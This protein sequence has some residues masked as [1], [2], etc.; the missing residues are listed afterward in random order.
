MTKRSSN[1][2][3]GTLVAAGAGYVAGI[4]TAPKSGK[5]TRGDIQSAALKTKKDAET[6]LKNLH[7]ELN[8]LLKRGKDQAG[9]LKDKAQ[10]GLDEAISSAQ[11]AKDKASQALSSIHDGDI[12][13]KDLKKAVDEVNKAIEHMKKYVRKQSD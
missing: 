11:K 1:F 2:A 7:S 6:S 5:Q 4:L 10:S 9:D 8:D 3:I 12:N 13:D